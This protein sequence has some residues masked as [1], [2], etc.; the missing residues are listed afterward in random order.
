MV[1]ITPRALAPTEFL[2]QYTQF[3]ADGDLIPDTYERTQAES[4]SLLGGGDADGDRWTD[5]LEFAL[6]SEPLGGQSTPQFSVLPTATFVTVGTRQ[7]GLPPWL[8]L[9]LESSQ[10]LAAW[11]A[12][13]GTPQ[14]NPVGNGL[15]MRQQTVPYP[16]GVPAKLFFRYCLYQKP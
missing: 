9:R 2:G 1:R 14:L 4:L 8:G 15:Y 16:A 6:G 5:L 13:A 10:N 12:A 3:D 7:R 11:T